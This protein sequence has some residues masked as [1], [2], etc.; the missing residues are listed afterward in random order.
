MKEILLD[1]LKRYRE[2]QILVD[3]AKFAEKNEVR[4]YLKSIVQT[5][6]GIIFLDGNG[7][8][9]AK[10]PAMIKNPNLNGGD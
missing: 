8:E 6:D 9:V 4:G 10:I 3:G 5:A 1:T 7:K 2:Q